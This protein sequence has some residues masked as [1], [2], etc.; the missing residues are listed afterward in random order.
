MKIFKIVVMFGIIASL[1]AVGLMYSNKGI[2]LMDDVS[3]IQTY[4]SLLQPEIGSYYSIQSITKKGSAI[5]VIGQKVKPLVGGKVTPQGQLV[6]IEVPSAKGTGLMKGPFLTV[7]GGVTH[8]FNTE[9]E[10]VQHAL[11]N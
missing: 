5:F 2:N 6:T 4:Q 10:V 3:K 8:Y 11:D 1:A 7:T 9:V